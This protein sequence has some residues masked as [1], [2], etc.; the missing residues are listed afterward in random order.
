MNNPTFESLKPALISLGFAYVG[1]PS[2][3]SPDP[4]K[5]LISALGLF[6]EDQKL[7]RMLLAWM[8][9]FGDLIHVERLVTYLKD[10]PPNERLILGVTAL[11]LFNAGDT[12]FKSLFERIRKEKQKYD[13]F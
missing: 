3:S 6:H 7:Y 1:E 12:R 4:E 10:M 9:R 11:K 8:E 13:H 2:K 5:T